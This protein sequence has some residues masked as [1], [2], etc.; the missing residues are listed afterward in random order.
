MKT[1]ATPQSK[2]GLI[3]AAIMLL[4]A[5]GTMCWG[6]SMIV[7][8]GNNTGWP[9]TQGVVISA[10]VD[11]EIRTRTNSSGIRT[12]G[13]VYVPR[14]AYRYTVNDQEYT[15]T[16]IGYSTSEVRY[17]IDSG[18]YAP[19]KP[20]TVYYNPEDPSDAVL[21]TGFSG[22]VFVPCVLGLF[23]GFLSIGLVVQELRK[24]RRATKSLQ[25]S[26]DLNNLSFG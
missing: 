10:S 3:F 4:V 26:Q 13:T 18:E 11:K 15:S 1:Q 25:A 19:G 20:I 16:T 21:V 2:S 23:F 22:S 5:I 12:Q 24:R 17:G 8:A 14:I 9:T 6:L 7:D